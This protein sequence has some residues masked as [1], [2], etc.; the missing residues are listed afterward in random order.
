M[1]IY[2]KTGD[3]GETGLFGGP[4]V[5]KDHRRI[6]AYGTIDE[7]NSVLGMVRAETLPTE[8][9][10]V[11]T[12]VQNALFAIGAELATPDPQKHGTA[13]LQASDTEELEQQ[14]D[15]Y[16]E[17]LPPL[18]H[19]ILPAGTRAAATLHL[20]RATCRRAERR[21]L[22][23]QRDEAIRG[24]LIVYL[25]RLS[26]FLFVLARYVNRVSDQS[27]TEWTKPNP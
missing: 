13:F 6:E 5:H 3:G 14:I 8:V 11:L 18:Q 4:R 12:K 2:T 7:L 16:D 22:S 23:A 26:D 9:D 21:V 1:K 27:E 20:A 15:H 17:H 25:N 19:F 10:M 24:E